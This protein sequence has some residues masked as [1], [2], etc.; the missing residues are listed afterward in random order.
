MMLLAALLVW[1]VAP[2]DA[3]AA[4]P[5]G[6]LFLTPERRAMLER[7][8]R[9]GL[10]EDASTAG[11]TISLDGTVMRSGGKTT[12]WIN[13]RPRHDDSFAAGTHASVPS[14]QSRRATVSA[15][16]TPSRL[17]VGESVNRA[18]GAQT[19]ILTPGAIR[20]GRSRAGG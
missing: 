5:L 2:A 15:D 9:T 13:G 6:R 14:S 8:R 18:T 3:L 17:R 4:E 16:V 19:D 20:I 1:A 10:L 11:E 12:I 7:Q